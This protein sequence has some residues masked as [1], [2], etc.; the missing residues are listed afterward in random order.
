MKVPQIS[1]VP[2]FHRPVGPVSQQKNHERGI[3]NGLPVG[4]VTAFAGKILHQDG[5]T[6]AHETD[7]Q[8]YGWKVCDGSPLQIDQY[9]DLYNAIGDLY[10]PASEGMFNLPNYSGYFLRGFDASGTVDKDR[11]KNKLLIGS[12]QDF[13]VQDHTHNYEEPQG[14]MPGDSGSAFASVVTA[15]TKG[16][17]SSNEEGQTV[18]KSD[19]ETR[20]SNYAVY[21]LVKC[22]PDYC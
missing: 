15:P 4:S 9:P 6:G 13:A 21:W 1:Q 22:V 10:G 14:A 20:P 2:M 3:Q 8:H 7:L 19:Y 12:K 5:K 16:V 17:N 11:K 18:L